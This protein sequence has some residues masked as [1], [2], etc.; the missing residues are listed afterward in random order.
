M[1]FEV[2]KISDWATET[3]QWTAGQATQAEQSGG[4]WGGS[5]SRPGGW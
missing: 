2:P 1:S 5:A 3:Q 4:D